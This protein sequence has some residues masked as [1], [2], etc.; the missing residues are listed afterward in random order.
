MIVLAVMAKT[1]YNKILDLFSDDE[2]LQ[3]YL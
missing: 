2:V 1:G 3:L